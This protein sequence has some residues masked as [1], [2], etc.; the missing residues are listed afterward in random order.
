MNV[1]SA[2]Q[3]AL[4]V[5]TIG[6]AEVLQSLWSGYG[7]ILRYKVENYTS[8]T[9]I[10]KHIKFPTTK[11]HPRGWNSDISHQRKLKSY[12]VESTWYTDWATSC[13]DSCK[14]PQCLSV[15]HDGDES[16]I[17]L[18]DL[19]AAGYPV[20]KGDANLDEMKVCLLWLANF[21]SIYINKKPIGLWEKGTYWHLN[22]RPEELKALEDIKLKNTAYLIDQKLDECQ[23]QT[24]VH[25]DA[26]LANFCFSKDSRQVAAVDFQYVG[27]GCGMKDVVYFIGSCISDDLCEKYVPE[28]LDYYIDALNISI[29]EQNLTIDLIALENE[30]R[31]LFP[32]AWADFHRFLKGWSP[33]HWKIHD[34][35]EKITQEVIKNL[36]FN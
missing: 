21:H 16:L 8:P 13:N 11:D 19:D 28:L 6:H 3:K 17:I 26:K 29:K 18:E 5:N 14:I 34:Y 2:I 23:F 35:G 32:V 10:V 24:I 15:V 31:D 33:N 9:V 4:N 27:Q 25:G 20:R 12:Q 30:C 1:V 36:S 22:T 7:N